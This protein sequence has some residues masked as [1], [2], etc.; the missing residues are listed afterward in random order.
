MSETTINELQI[1]LSYLERHIEEQDKVI[2]S[3]QNQLEKL[4]Q[5]TARLEDQAKARESAE[6]S[7]PSQERPPH[8]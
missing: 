3:L 5:S 2:Y 6:G 8:Y 7:D 1:K 4:E